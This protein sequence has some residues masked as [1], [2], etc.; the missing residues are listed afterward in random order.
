VA[1]RVWRGLDLAG[2]V[3]ERFVERFWSKVDRKGDGCWEWNRY[4]KPNGYGQFTLVKGRFV[5]AHTVS[6]ALTN[7]PIAAGQVICHHC[8]NPPCVR[9]DH[10]FAGTQ[11]DN[12]HDMF[13]KG[14]TVRSSG[15]DRANAVLTEEAVRHIRAA[16]RYRGL[17]RDLASEYGVS[18][19]TIRMVRLVRKWVHIS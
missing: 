17:I 13:T 4:R 15:T 10:L 7:G 11:S 3:N 1:E 8:D 19:H 12:A 18:P 2:L 14:R 6:F 16:S 5:G 9:P